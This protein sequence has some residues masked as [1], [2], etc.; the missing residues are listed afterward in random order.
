MTGFAFLVIFGV[1]FGTNAYY[2]WSLLDLQQVLKVRSPEYWRAIGSPQGLAAR[3]GTAMLRVLFT[4]SFST[5]CERA[6]CGDLL[7]R[8]RIAFG[9]GLVFTMTVM[10]WIVATKGVAGIS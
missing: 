3:D 2:L 9:I 6:G 10:V 1:A 7:L 5:E 4:S 8:V